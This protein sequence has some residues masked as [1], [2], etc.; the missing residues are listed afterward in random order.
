MITAEGE[1]LILTQ[2]VTR[3]LLKVWQDVQSGKP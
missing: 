1:N 2:Q 3:Y